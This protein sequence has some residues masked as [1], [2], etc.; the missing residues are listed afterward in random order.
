PLASIPWCS[1]RPMSASAARPANS[2]G[3]S[4]S[5]P[6][7]FTG[8]EAAASAGGQVKDAPASRTA[9]TTRRQR[10]VSMQQDETVM[11]VPSVQAGSSPAA[12]TIA[13]PASAGLEEMRRQPWKYG[14]RLV[15]EV[16]HV[17]RILAAVHR[18]RRDRALHRA[19]GL[20]RR[21]VEPDQHGAGP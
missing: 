19:A 3:L 8:S 13:I 11:P 12:A 9:A 6:A 17:N 1:S 16:G 2:S 5:V 15:R 18:R 4:D 10:R 14:C 20:R 7:L 21:R